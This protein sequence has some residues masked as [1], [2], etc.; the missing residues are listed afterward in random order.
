[1][2]SDRRYKKYGSALT[3]AML[4]GSAQY[5]NATNTSGVHGPVINP[6]DSSA[7]YRI[8][9]VPGEDGA[10]DKWANRF[11]YQRAYNKKFRWRVITQFRERN[12]DFELDYVRAELLYYFK[13]KGDGI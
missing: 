10:N 3:L 13:P 1:M 5:A 7:M 6:E 4:I 9:F 8:S 11:Y 12:N 2:K